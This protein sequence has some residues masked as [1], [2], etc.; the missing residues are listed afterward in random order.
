[1]IKKNENAIKAPKTIE[2][3][4]NIGEAKA[5]S[6][7]EVKSRNIPMKGIET[8]ITF[9]ISGSSVIVKIIPMRMKSME[10]LKR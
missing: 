7:N 3:K 1:M 9:A 2:K 6:Q 8:K 10:R 4:P 5:R